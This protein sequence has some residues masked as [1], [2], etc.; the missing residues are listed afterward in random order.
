[1]AT[2]V[3]L[4][5]LRL[6]L[7]CHF[8]YEGVWKIENRAKFTAEP[9]LSEAK[10]PLAPFFRAMLDDPEGSKRLTVEVDEGGRPVLGPD[11]R[12]VVKA[13]STLEAW[14]ALKDEAARKYDLSDQQRAEAEKLYARYEAWLNEYLGDNSEE[15]VGYLGSLRRFKEE[16]AR[17]GNGTPYYKKRIWDRRVELDSEVSGRIATAAC[18]RCHRPSLPSLVAPASDPTRVP[19]VGDPFPLDPPIQAPETGHY[20]KVEKGWLGYIDKLGGDYKAALWDLLDEEQQER[21]YFKANWNPLK[22]SRIE[23]INFAVTYG[24]TA[25][26]LCLLLGLF[27]RPAALGGAAFMLFVI[28]S[29]PNWPT[30]YPPAG[31]EGGHALLIEKSFI[32]MVALVLLATTAAGRWGGLDAWLSRWLPFPLGARKNKDQT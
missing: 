22:W 23:Q 3:M 29:Q 2:V 21:G 18:V 12:P 24:L 16:T 17:G 14:R 9:F 28:L 10:G 31:P 6:S 32:E 7:G 11:D 25:I 1:M 13:E 19:L 8:L 30:I 5:V 27:T 4:V 26:G 20:E 15:I